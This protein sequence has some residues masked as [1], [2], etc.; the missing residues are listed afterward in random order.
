M[1]GAL[2]DS[3]IILDVLTE[4]PVWFEWSSQALAQAAERLPIV[5]NPII[6]AE[7][8]IRFQRIEELDD[9]LPPAMFRRDALPWEGGFLS[10]KCFRSYR[11]QG[12]M[13]RSPLPDFY[14]GA[15]AAVAG[16]TL[17]TR[18]AARYRSYFPKLVIIAP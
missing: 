11:R 5:I 10:G 16:L 9:A 8:S 6:Y 1:T 15:H 17:L 7:V 3:N 13:R 12:G 14:I 2:V 4:D 18:D